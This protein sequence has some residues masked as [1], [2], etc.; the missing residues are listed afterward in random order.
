MA[1]D[2]LPFLPYML[3]LETLQQH[4]VSTE[5]GCGLREDLHRVGVVSHT[6]QCLA[7]VGHHT[8]RMENGDVLAPLDHLPLENGYAG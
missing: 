6:L 8:P 7:S 4:P 1:L 3:L 5:A 2:D